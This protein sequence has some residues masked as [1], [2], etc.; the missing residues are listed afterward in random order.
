MKKKILVVDDDEAIL[1]VVQIVLEEENYLVQTSLNG[2]C[3]RELKND[4]PDL[5]LLDVLLSGEDGRELCQQLKGNEKT[6]HIPVILFSAHVNARHAAASSG[7][8]DFLAKPFH[9]DA[10]TDMMKRHLSSTTGTNLP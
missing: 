8:N 10:L 7:A 9:M 2:T 1:D 3:F 4:L 5:I 6:R